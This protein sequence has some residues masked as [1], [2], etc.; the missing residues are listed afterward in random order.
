MGIQ[1]E[2]KGK[3]RKEMVT[4]IHSQPTSHHLTIL[5]KKL[6]EIL[7]SIPTALGGGNHRHTGIIMDPAVYSNMTCRID[8]INLGNP[9]IYPIGL[10]ANA[11]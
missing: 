8:F 5:E 9:I 7:A 4:E 11:E 10:A 2:I 3:L 1:S 6:I